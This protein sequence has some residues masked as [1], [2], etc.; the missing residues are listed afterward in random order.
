MPSQETQPLFDVARRIRMALC[1]GYSELTNAPTTTAEAEPEPVQGGTLVVG[2]EGDR[3]GV[4]DLRGM[5]SQVDLNA[6]E[7]LQRKPK[8]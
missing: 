3:V 4:Q 2:I 8:G 1:L 6:L 7:G 5:L